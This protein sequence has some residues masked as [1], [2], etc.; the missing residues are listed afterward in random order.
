MTAFHGELLCLV[1]IDS[2]D[3]ITLHLLSSPVLGRV[4]ATAPGATTRALNSPFPH[5]RWTTTPGTTSHTLYEQCLR[6]LTSHRIYMCKGCETGPTG[7][8]SLSEKNRAS[9][10]LQM[11][12]QRQHI[13]L[14]Y[15]KTL[16]VG[17]AGLWTNGLPLSRTAVIQSN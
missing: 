6:S 3:P 1:L 14:S 4:T 17:L 13:L 15:F 11:P 7:L 16:S 5:G 10:R 9:N 12:L 2:P 8:S